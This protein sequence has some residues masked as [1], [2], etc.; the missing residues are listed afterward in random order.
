MR[1][2]D[3]ESLWRRRNDPDTA[4]FQGWSLPYP[5]ATAVSFVDAVV[6][7]DGTPPADGWF[8]MAVDD[9]T[10]GASVGDLALQFTFDGR[11][12]EIGYTVA[13]EAQGQH[14]ASDAAARLARW[15]FDTVHVSRVGAEMHPDNLASARV[16]ERIGMV[17]EGR[18]RRSF[19]VGDDNSDNLLYG[20]TGDTWAQWTDRV[21]HE[22][23]D[24][25]L[26]EVVGHNVDAVTRLAMHHSQERLV[27]SIAAW[28]AVV[29]APDRGD[30]PPMR[31][32]IRAV[33]ADGDVVGALLMSEPDEAHPTPSVWRMMVDRLHQGRGIGQRVLD[34]AVE[35]ARRWGAE[36][37]V[38][39]WC[40]LPGTAGP[41]YLASGFE[42][43]GVNGDGEIEA[44]LRL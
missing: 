42:P 26:V 29:H 23:T 34:L 44:R 37:L 15:L 12:A 35:Q 11:C 22:P 19:W 43:T 4:R 20:M 3:V 17:F 28:F 16:A 18:T 10:T 5:R 27:A 33:T 24:V 39:S 25:R 40:D 1:H 14:I 30:G 9:S 21:R 13:S 41:M 32:W 8:Q 2:A 7:L 6:G 31:P 38:V 36:D